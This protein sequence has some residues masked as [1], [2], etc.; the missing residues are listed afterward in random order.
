MMFTLVVPLVFFTITSSIANLSKKT[1]LTKILSKTFLVFI[2]TS[3]ISAVVMLI[4][5]FFINPAKGVNIDIVGSEQEKLN[6][7]TQISKAL[8]VGDFGELLSK[9]HMLALIVFSL[10][11]GISLRLVDKE[12]KLAKS[13]EILSQTMLKIVKIVMYYAPIGVFAYF[14]NLISSY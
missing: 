12:N 5:M 4:P 9:S 6:I 13:F 10:L 3:A 7:L 11:F 14:A 1:K 8:T 2:I